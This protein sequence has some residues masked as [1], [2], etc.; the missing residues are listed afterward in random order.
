MEEL[1]KI[2]GK[3]NQFGKENGLQLTYMEE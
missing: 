1:L 2:Y 3:V